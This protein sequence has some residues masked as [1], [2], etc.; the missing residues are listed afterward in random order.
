MMQGVIVVVLYLAVLIGVR[1]ALDPDA[2]LWD[3]TSQGAFDYM[4][5]VAA[6]VAAV[7]ILVGVMGW[8][9]RYIL[10]ERP[11][12]RLT[13]P[14]WLWVIPA[15]FVLSAIGGLAAA[16]WDDFETGTLLILFVGAMLIGVGEELT[17]R[18]YLLTAARGRYTE[19][20]ACFFSSFLFAVLHFFGIIG[21]EAVGETITQVVLAFFAGLSFYVIRR[22]TGSLFVGIVIHGL[23]DFA[24]FTGNGP[25]EGEEALDPPG[26]FLL[27][28]IV[29]WIV[30]LVALY[31]IFRKKNT[32]TAPA[33][34]T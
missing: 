19:A 1:L 34:A 27:P 15:L 20:G 30:T 25:G 31:L 28:V 2:E 23:F 8:Y 17:V 26:L 7:L 33:P 16:P 21:G 4:A 11:E 22:L 24:A 32:S 29:M 12:L 18:G 14:K 10:Y 3:S 9:S 5:P 13:G 6:A